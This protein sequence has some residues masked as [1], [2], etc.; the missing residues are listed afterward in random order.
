MFGNFLWR[1]GEPGYPPSLPPFTTPWRPAAAVAPSGKIF[2][3]L[4]WDSPSPINKAD[5]Q[6]LAS[7]EETLARWQQHYATMLN[8]P[9]AAACPD[10][11]RDA[12]SASEATNVCSDTPILHEVRDAIARL[13]NGRAACPDGIPPEQHMLCS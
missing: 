11:D 8:H 1:G 2:G 5:S 7:K 12:A 4:N 9:P 3:K 6:P 13:K 10:L